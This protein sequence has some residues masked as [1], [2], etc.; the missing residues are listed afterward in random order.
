LP[1][2]QL[3]KQKCLGLLR[4]QYWWREAEKSLSGAPHNAN[5]SETVWREH[6]R[7][8]F[9]NQ[10]IPESGKVCQGILRDSAKQIGL[11]LSMERCGWDDIGR[12]QP[13]H[14]SISYHH[15]ILD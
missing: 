11:R 1:L 15:C 7:N 13:P 6:R 9:A 2:A 12:A 4:V 5:M 10:E 3:K 14:N 8:C